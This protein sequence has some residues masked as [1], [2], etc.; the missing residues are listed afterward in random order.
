MLEQ[1]PITPPS[2]LYKQWEGMPRSLAFEAAYRAGADQELEACLQW[3]S[4]FY[5]METW[6]QKDL[7]KFRTARR[8]KP[9]TLAEEALET[10]MQLPLKVWGERDT[11]PVL[12][13]I[14]RALERL[15]E[16][17]NNG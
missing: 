15:Q 17:E 7:E 10:F 1:H 6:M 8:P 12:L 9:P 5:C 16:L 3:F 13:K 14:R 11:G 4:E 2:E